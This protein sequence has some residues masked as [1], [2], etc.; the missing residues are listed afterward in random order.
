MLLDGEGVARKKLPLVEKGVVK[1]VVYARSTA[2]KMSNSEFAG[3]AGEIAP[4][5][6]GLPL[7]NELG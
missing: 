1:R 2:A 4:S 6:H 3:K 7:P 5:G